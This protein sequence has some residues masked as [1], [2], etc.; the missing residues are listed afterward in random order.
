MECKE[1]FK[2]RYRIPSARSAWW[3]YD[4]AGAYF[5]TICTA[6]QQHLFGEI[7]Q[8][9]MTLSPI[10]QI[11]QTC[12][13]EIPLHCEHVELGAFVVMPNHVHGVLILHRPITANIRG[14]NNCL[15]DFGAVPDFNRDNAQDS[16]NLPATLRFR[17]QGKNSVSSIIGGYKSAAAKPSPDAALFNYR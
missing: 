1:K 4:W 13:H 12:W 5:I 16:E 17:N 14:N 9:K 7:T 6:H 10:G 11:A 2:N 8:Q 15:R 3:R